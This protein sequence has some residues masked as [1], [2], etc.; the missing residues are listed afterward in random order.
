MS[1]ARVAAQ[2]S[3]SILNLAMPGLICQPQRVTRR[4]IEEINAEA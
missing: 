4:E 1:R 2:T 3:D